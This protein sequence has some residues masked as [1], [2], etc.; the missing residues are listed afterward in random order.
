MSAFSSKSDINCGKYLSGRTDR[1]T[2]SQTHRQGSSSGLKYSVLKWLNIKKHTHTR[3]H[4][5]IHNTPN[6]R[7]CTYTALYDRK[8]YQPYPDNWYTIFRQYNNPIPTI[9]QLVR[10]NNNRVGL[11]KVFSCIIFLTDFFENKWIC[12][13]MIEEGFAFY[14]MLIHVIGKKLWPL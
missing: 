8:A 14:Y 10:Q 6:D 5:Q 1:H 9:Q 13:W 4:T 7:Y 12:P 11:A 3:K 2:D